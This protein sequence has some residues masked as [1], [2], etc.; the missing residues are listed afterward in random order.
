[1]TQDIGTKKNSTRV[2][3]YHFN[4]NAYRQRK[5]VSWTLHWKSSCHVVDDII[6][7][8]KT[9]SYV[10]TRQPVAVIK[11]QASNVVFSEIDGRV[12][13]TIE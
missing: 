8:V 1:M 10:R 4:K 2:F 13:V 7:N 12:V 3:W 9:K 11:G 6:C 5:R